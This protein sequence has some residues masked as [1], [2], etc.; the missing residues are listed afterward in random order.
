MPRHTV[1][2]RLPACLVNDAQREKSLT[3]R[4]DEGARK[5]FCC[6]FGDDI[7]DRAIV[8]QDMRR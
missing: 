6:R 7:A 8:I 1:R 5:L 3:A 2:E 4:S